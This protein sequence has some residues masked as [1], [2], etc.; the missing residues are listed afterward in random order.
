VDLRIIKAG[1]LALCVCAAPQMVSAQTMQWTDKGYV[2]VNG[3]VQ[4]GSHDLSTTSTFSIY[5]EDA[6]VASSQKIKGAGWFEF[7]GAYRVRGK[8]LLAGA[9]F[10]HASSTG[11]L[12]VN[13][14]IPDPVHFGQLRAVTTSQ[15]GAKHAEN[16]L[17][18]DAVWMI[19]VAEKLDVGVFAGPSIFF[20]TQDTITTLTVTEP[21]PT[22]SAPFASVKK[23][24][25]GFNAGV[26]LQYLVHKQLAVGGL[27][28]FTWGS[29][30]IV[31]GSKSLTVGGFQ[32]GGGV[33]YRF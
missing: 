29:A 30:K 7:G 31:T 6:T 3:G 17:H 14:S 19:P 9:F 2:T 24:A 8:N 33:R 11:D 13:A 32:L 12:T 25:G 15:G 21:G 28:R 16:A 10:T 27:A 4:M 22:V 18:L 23:T 26:D 20:V 5:D 1:I